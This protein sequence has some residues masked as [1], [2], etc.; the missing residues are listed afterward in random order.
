MLS[1]NF[2]PDCDPDTPVCTNF[3]VFPYCLLVTREGELVTWV[4]IEDFYFSA[5]RLEMSAAKLFS[6]TPLRLFVLR[7]V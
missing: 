4:L 3:N 7:A 5:Q 6:S 2:Q 1:A